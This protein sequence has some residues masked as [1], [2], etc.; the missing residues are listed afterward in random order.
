M[1][2]ELDTK[3]QQVIDAF[4]EID[5]Q[6][7]ASGTFVHDTKKGIWGP[8]SVANCY[9][10]FKEI[11]L[12][13]YESFI[14]VGCGDGRITLL[15]S[16]FTKAVGIEYDEKLVE[17]GKRV[18]QELDLVSAELIQGDFFDHDWSKYEVIFTNPDSG[19]QFGME[20]KLY[21]EMKG[22]LI[23]YNSVF[24]PLQLKQG[25][26]GWVNQIPIT[27]YTKN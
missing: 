10:F 7:L 14:D 18:Q 24:K 16:L 1:D 4:E 23:V 8:A 26:R 21:E 9:A 12:D 20:K 15:A 5:K 27:I 22:M 3:A 25:K 13:K 11:E 17:R 19:F 2:P 6:L